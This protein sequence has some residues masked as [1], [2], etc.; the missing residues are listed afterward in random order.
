MSY[1]ASPKFPV[2]IQEKLDCTLI[3]D[4]LPV[5][6]QVLLEFEA[7]ELRP[8]INGDCM[9]D[10]FV[11]SGQNINSRVPVLCGINTGQHSKLGILVD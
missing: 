3:V 10:R 5:T 1:F 2:P 6:R 8:P 4:L 11:V 7:M 9:D